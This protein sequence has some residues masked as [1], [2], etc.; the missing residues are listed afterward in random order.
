MSEKRRSRARSAAALG[1]QP[2]ADFGPYAPF[3]GH[4]PDMLTFAPGEMATRDMPKP[5]SLE[6]RFVV[7][8]LSGP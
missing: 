6:S 7:G 4:T 5:A 1:P 3:L 2:S 8:E